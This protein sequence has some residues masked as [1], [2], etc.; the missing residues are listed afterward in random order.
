[1]E[2]FA[3]GKY[4]LYSDNLN[5]NTDG[6]FDLQVSRMSILACLG[7]EAEAI[8][9]MYLTRLQAVTEVDID[10]NINLNRY[11]VKKKQKNM[12]DYYLKL[13]T[14]QYYSEPK[15]IVENSEVSFN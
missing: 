15:I 10:R 11:L 8:R 3:H 9:D 7:G 5:F 4:I 1:M 2:V 6:F 12:D 13:L 14:N